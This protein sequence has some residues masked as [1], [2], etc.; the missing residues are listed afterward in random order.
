MFLKNY[1]TSP[2]ALPLLALFCSCLAFLYPAFFL[3]MKHLIVPLLALIMFGMGLTL[4]LKDFQRVFKKPG[5]I[6]VG[7]LIQYSVMPLASFLISHAFGFSHFLAAG[8]ILVGASPGGTASNLICFLSRGN[9]ALSIT[10]TSISTFVAVIATPFITLLLAG[11]AVPVPAMKMFVSILKII[12]LPVSAGVVINCLCPVKVKM[13]RQFAPFISMAAIVVIISIVVAVNRDNLL[14]IGPLLFMAVVLHNLSGLLIGYFLSRLIGL[15]K[16][17]ARTIAI[18]TGMQN[19]GLSVALA[20]KYFSPVAALPG[21][22]FSIWHNLSGAL[23]AA[24]WRRET[25]T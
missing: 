8:F 18:E 12:V 15:D 6:L 7:I 2:F 17:T 13:M 5:V 3:S 1:I 20:I 22:I 9:V 19:S 10:L 14:S 23:L 16:L 25:K 4:E 24:F 21:A 11:H